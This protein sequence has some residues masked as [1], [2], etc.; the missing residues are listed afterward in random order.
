MSWSLARLR[1]IER[2]PGGTV[3]KSSDSLEQRIIA[4][5]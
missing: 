1:R 2:W 4:F 3:R 5:A